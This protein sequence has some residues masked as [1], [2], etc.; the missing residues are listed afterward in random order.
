LNH[1]NFADYVLIKKKVTR[2]ILIL[3][4]IQQLRARCNLQDI[5]RVFYKGFKWVGERKNHADIHHKFLIINVWVRI[6]YKDFKWVNERKNHADIRHEFLIIKMSGLG[7]RNI[8]VT[9]RN[10]CL[11]LPNVLQ[12]TNDSELI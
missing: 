2:V 9:F 6:F 10:V 12:K 5:M 4:C 7:L 3:V 1:Y 11:D 8:K